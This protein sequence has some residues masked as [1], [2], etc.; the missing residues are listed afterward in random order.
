MVANDFTA[1]FAVHRNI[2][3]IFFNGSAAE[4]CFKRHAL[5][6]LPGMVSLVRL[7]STSPAHAA[8]RLAAKRE[9]WRVILDEQ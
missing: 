1:F 5:S 8:L 6:S 2:R 3:R 4:T 9:A 7:P